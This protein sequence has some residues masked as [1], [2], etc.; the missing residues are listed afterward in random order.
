M[1]G[2]SALESA[3]SK[4]AT[5][6][7][8]KEFQSGIMEEVMSIVMT[9]KE[10]PTTLTDPAA[11]ATNSAVLGLVNDVESHVSKY[12]A[13]QTFLSGDVKES[14]AAEFKK[15]TKNIQGA[16]GGDK[17]SDDAKSSGTKTS[18]GD[19][20]SGTGIVTQA[21]GGASRVM[22]MGALLAAGVAAIALL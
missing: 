14:L 9:Q 13:T 12:V 10:L 21:T 22:G 11:F 8:F 2:M 15:A 7:G 4:F 5:V 6:P 1:P 19:A 18:G 17:S 20:P 16:T 3:Y